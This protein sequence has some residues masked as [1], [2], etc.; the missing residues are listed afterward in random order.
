MTTLVTDEQIEQMRR[1]IADPTVTTVAAAP[2]LTTSKTDTL[3][4][5]TDSDGVPSPGDRLRYTIALANTGNT[6]ATAVHFR[7]LAPP[8]TQIVAGSVTTSSGT[9]VSSD[10]IDVD[11][12]AFA[13]GAT[14]T[15]AFEVLVDNPI[16][17]GI[18]S[19]SNQGTLE[20]AGL[21][22]VLTDDPDVGG[23]AD[24]T[25]TTITASPR[26]LAE[27]TVSLAV[28]ADQDGFSSPGDALEYSVR[29]R[30][31]GNTAAT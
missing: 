16:A 30:N 13:A 26:L 4:A 12:G 1:M 8:N 14:A 27:K 25:V 29:L 17:T 24:P 28:D 6:A 15:I 3:A 21:P 11:L 7:D 20:S 5:D 23:T 2:V 9:I 19:V 18:R 10:P 31:V 22:A